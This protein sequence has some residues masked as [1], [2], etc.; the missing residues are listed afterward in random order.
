MV[1]TKLVLDEFTGYADSPHLSRFTLQDAKKLGKRYTLSSPVCLLYGFDDGA[2]ILGFKNHTNMRE[3][4]QQ[5]LHSLYVN[6]EGL[7]YML[8]SKNEYGKLRA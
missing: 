7:P 2:A 5:V 4:V 6:G 1:E 3:F 8:I